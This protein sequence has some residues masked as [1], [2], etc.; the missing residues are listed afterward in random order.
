LHI[1]NQRIFRNR[2]KQNNKK[3]TI[4]I[5]L[6]IV[7]LLF[8]G[9]RL[10]LLTP[11]L[12]NDYQYFENA[13]EQLDKKIS[14]QDILSQKNYYQKMLNNLQKKYKDE[15]NNAFVNLLLGKAYFL[16][17]TLEKDENLKKILLE[18]SIL[19]LRRGL[20]LLNKDKYPSFHLVLG[21]AYFEKGIDYYFE[22]LKEL[23]KSK[24]MG[25]YNYDV[26]KRMA[27]I[28]LKKEEYKTSIKLYKKLLKRRENAENYF[29]LGL[30]Y[31]LIQKPI[32][33]EEY[34]NYAVDYYKNF[35]DFNKTFLVYSYFYLGKIYF[36]KGTYDIAE[37]YLKK[38][39][40]IYSKNL[41]TLNLLYE[42]YKKIGNSSSA[43]SI[44]QKIKNLEK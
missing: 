17:N 3:R 10:F 15:P 28:Y 20:A 37:T 25:L 16:K 26:E 33:S 4:F 11:F 18:K 14:A 41:D 34:L 32:P 42:L 27:Y 31:Y 23:Q 12:S 13:N 36:D 39:L 5:L 9:W 8:V 30:N 1:K 44:K 22:S 29:Y 24:K 6:G 2:K 35:P 40:Q 21:K 7:L 19:Y 43:R 38:S